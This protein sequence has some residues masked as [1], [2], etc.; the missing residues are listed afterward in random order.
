MA[1]LTKLKLSLKTGHKSFSGTDARIYLVFAGPGAEHVYRLPTR[2]GDLEA[3]KLDIYTAECPDGPDLEAVQHVLLVNGMDGP[4]PA[5]RVLWVRLEAV[6]A[7][8][9]SWLLA[10]AML[11]R[12]LETGDARAPVAFLPMQ[13]PLVR[14]AVEDAVGVPTIRLT[15]IA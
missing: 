8:G 7:A 13:R 11:E 12:W 3:G 1:P 14:L 10:D 9:R 15:R 5:W 4:S 2:P 6:D